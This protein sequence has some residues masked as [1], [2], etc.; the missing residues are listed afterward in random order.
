MQRAIM[1]ALPEILK[2]TDTNDLIRKVGTEFETQGRYVRIDLQEYGWCWTGAF[3]TSFYRALN[4]LEK[5]GL[6]AWGRGRGHPV[7]STDGWI[8]RLDPTAEEISA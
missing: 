1:A 3:V 4:G 6:I 5:R 8:V 2:E 7:V